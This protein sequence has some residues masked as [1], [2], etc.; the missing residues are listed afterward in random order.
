M[1]FPSHHAVKNVT[2]VVTVKCIDSFYKLVLMLLWADSD[3]G[4]F[5]SRMKPLQS[6]QGFIGGGWQRTIQI[7]S[8]IC[9]LWNVC[10][11]NSVY[12]FDEV[13]I[14]WYTQSFFLFFYCV[15]LHFHWFFWWYALSQGQKLFW[16]FSAKFSHNDGFNGHQT[17]ISSCL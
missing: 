6:L 1:Q 11:G 2:E 15:P 5:Q 13:V 9:L 8:T 17:L 16:V 3:L 12:V 10:R 4:I 14:Q 7:Y